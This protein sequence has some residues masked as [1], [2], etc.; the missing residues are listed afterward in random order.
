MD[1][2]DTIGLGTAV[3]GHAVLLAL[4]IFG[5][6]QATR[7]IGSDGGGGGG[8]GIAVELVSEAGSAT[9]APVP[10]EA[11]EVPVIQEQPE[12]QPDAVVEPLPVP[13]PVQKTVTP[14]P[15]KIQ[16]KPVPKTVRGGTGGR[17][18]PDFNRRIENVLGG[19]GGKD[20]K[21][22]DGDGDG[23]GPSTQTPGQI[24]AAA[25]A[26]IAKQ[27]RLGNCMPSG[28]DV[29]KVLTRVTVKLAKNGALVAITEVTQSGQ[30]ASNRPQLEPIKRCITDSIR[31]IGRFTGLDPKTHSSWELI[32]V[33]FKSR[34]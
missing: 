34:G 25:R 20:P 17:G 19:G 23:E 7:P 3:G 6:F 28:V 22:G 13:K 15:A 26:T 1:R 14:Q 29:N 30:T 18:S 24:A 12:I 10:V 9:P 21:T 27:I 32:T 11:E 2:D 31:K 5:L 4:L 33:P 8:D 16:P